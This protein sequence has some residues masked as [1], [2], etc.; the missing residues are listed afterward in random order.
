MEQMTTKQALKPR[1]VLAPSLKTGA[2]LGLSAFFISR[3]LIFQNL[4][5]IVPAFLGC[6]S[7]LGSSFYVSL[8]FSFLGLLTK[9]DT[10]SC[11]IKYIIYLGLML[12]LNLAIPKQRREKSLPFRC[13]AS[14]TAILVAGL[15]FAVLNSFSFYYTVLALLETVLCFSV[16]MVLE[17]GVSIASKKSIKALIPEKEDIISIALMVGSVIAGAGDLTLTGVD[18]SLM[19]SVLC[20]LA[21]GYIYGSAYGAVTSAM[22]TL[23]LY[24]SSSRELELMCIFACAVVFSSLSKSLKRSIYAL[25]F[26][27]SCF[28]LALY[29]NKELLREEYI[30]SYAL[31]VIIFLVLPLKKY[32]LI[33]QKPTNADEYIS[34]LR[35]ITTQRLKD[36]SASF[37][38]LSKT[39]SSLSQRQSNGEKK[40]VS[41]IIDDVA[42]QQCV[43][44]N[45]RTFCWENNFYS[46]Y[47]T[48]FSMLS[49]CE[50]KGF[51]EEKD[52]GDSF[53]SS[54]IKKEKFISAIN[55]MYELHKTNKAWE[56]KINESREL[57]SQQLDGVSSIIN[58][59]SNELALDMTYK[60]RLSEKA[61]EILEENSIYVNSLVI[62]ESRAEQTEILI[63]HP[64]CYGAKD[65]EKYI[66]PLLS[67][68]LKKHFCKEC[69]QCVTS[70]ENR[71]NICTL[72]LVEEKNYRILPAVAS[73]KKDGS[74]K[75]GD[76]TTF[77]PL[78]EGKYLL[79][80]SDG[81]GSGSF[82][83]K[84]SAATIELFEDFITAGF[85]KETAVN[86]I[87]SVLVLKSGK[88][89]FSTLDVC[90][91][92]L[93]NGEAEFI[94][95]GAVTSFIKHE[96]SVEVIKS[97]SLPVGILS[98]VEPEVSVKKLADN[99]IIVMISDGVL[100]SS[101]SLNNKEGFIT[102]ILENMNTNSPNE[103]AD[104]ILKTAIENGGGVVEDDMTVLAARISKRRL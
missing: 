79:A 83:Q 89:S 13:C 22:V 10:N 18:F 44:C 38:K 3:V 21:V 72:R 23:V 30:F 31:A 84:E 37:Y 40:E 92:D 47:Q 34:R 58:E 96:G 59:L 64:P 103:I 101:N 80:L 86:M 8:V 85:N 32:E 49:A 88:E 94:K 33:K 102:S 93:F 29:M 61:Q 76:S 65:C 99:D 68:S 78:P 91:V 14:T 82:A 70:R 36:F 63:K 53:L 71:Q 19:L 60:E 9:A 62:S 50:E 5:P 87:N 12:A 55:R 67:Q 69:V 54:C 48:M 46:T 24:L 56:N 81:M 20:V 15:I 16:F 51:A 104:E 2:L 74:Y 41:A 17:R 66:I 75:S 52:L 45:M 39:L 7:F 1:I 43:K 77:I 73:T 35:A 98:K 4:N 26:S 90:T 42:A 57:V 95:I 6:L 97:S 27:I 25:C 100:D 11:L 28:I